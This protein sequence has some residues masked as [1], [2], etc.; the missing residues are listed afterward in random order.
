[1]DTVIYLANKVWDIVEE[2]E[3]QDEQEVL[4]WLDTLNEISV[5]G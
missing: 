3:L 4:S 2:N 5:R 1:M